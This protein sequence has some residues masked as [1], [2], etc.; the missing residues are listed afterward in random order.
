LIEHV[1][2]EYALALPDYTANFD[3][4]ADLDYVNSKLDLK[5]DYSY[6]NEALGNL[7]NAMMNFSSS[8]NNQFANKADK[9]YVDEQLSE[10]ASLAY[11]DA[12]LEN[13]DMS[14]KADKSYVDAQD[15]GIVDMLQSYSLANHTHDMFPNL[16]NIITNITPTFLNPSLKIVNN[17]SYPKTTGEQNCLMSLNAAVLNVE[18]S[19]FLAVCRGLAST[20]T[21]AQ[22]LFGFTRKA[23]T[24]DHFGFINL[25]FLPDNMNF[26]TPTIAWKANSIALNRPVSINQDLTVFGDTSCQ[27]KLNVNGELLVYQSTSLAETKSNRT[28]PC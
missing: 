6:S 28:V 23:S 9:S 17:K 27:Q 21:N 12:Q 4:K 11:V 26:D 8:V 13:V 19:A 22:S 7:T 1:H 5:A 14:G 2:P 3:S 18:Q 24:A 16:L 15:I 25:G 10:K 20:D